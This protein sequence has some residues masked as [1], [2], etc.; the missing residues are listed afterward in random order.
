LDTLPRARLAHLPTPLEPM[1]NIAADLGL[2]AAWVK[3]DDCTGLAL[4]GNKARQLEFYFGEALAEGADTILITGAVQSNYVRQAAAAAA[5]L[6]MAAH[7]QL[8]ART[9]KT[10]PIYT[11]SGNVL[12]DRMLGA[13]IHHYAHG[14]DEA[15][16]DRALEAIA[17]GLRTAG[18]RPYV[19]HLGPGH[20]PLGALGYVDAARELLAQIEADGIALDEIVVPSGS[21]AT[22][23]GLLIGLRA[24]GCDLPVL[25]ACVRRGAE[26]QRPRLLERCQ[27]IA[28]LLGIA[29][30]VREVDLRL[31]DAA[32]APGYGQLNRVTRDAINLAARREGLILDPVYS[33]KAMAGFVAAAEATPGARLLF[34]HT[35]GAPAVFAYGDD[36]TG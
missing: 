7:V 19:I 25:G 32:L 35:G 21:G 12:L 17:D 6:G 13:T 15:G 29:N 5:R 2:A 14:E 1:R 36:L 3:R 10:D 22:H 33:G 20:R 8:E 31:T 23:A 9:P 16:A 26:A 18:G 4:G 34:V 30:P 24:L 28:A 11:G 27:E